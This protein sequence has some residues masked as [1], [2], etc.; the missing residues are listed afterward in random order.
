MSKISEALEY[1]YNLVDLQGGC[2]EYWKNYRIIEKELKAL[3]III[4]KNVDTTFLK[5]C[6]TLSEYNSSVA[7]LNDLLQ[8]EYDLLKEVL[9]ND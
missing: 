8:E 4:K 1:F 2:D 3:D 7:P 9:Q 5:G 6:L